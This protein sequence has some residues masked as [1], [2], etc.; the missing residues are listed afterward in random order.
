MARATPSGNS[1]GGARRRVLGR[2]GRSTSPRPRGVRELEAELRNARAEGKRHR[3][4]REA[5]ERA[6][7]AAVRELETTAARCRAALDAVL[8]EIRAVLPG[9]EQWDPRVHEALP[10]FDREAAPFRPRAELARGSAF[11][12]ERVLGAH[13]V[14]PLLAWIALLGVG[15][16]GESTGPELGEGAP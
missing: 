12:V 9:C 4:E 10:R 6:D 11:T 7:Q 15:G 13:P 8:G 14:A 16:R 1:G 5:R 2:D 3:Q